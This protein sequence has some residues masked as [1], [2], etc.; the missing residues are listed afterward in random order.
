MQ[1]E[2]ENGDASIVTI[3][4]NNEDDVDSNWDDESDNDSA[5]M[6]EDNTDDLA[7]VYDCSN[8]QEIS[9]EN[10]YTTSELIFVE[11]YDLVNDFTIPRKAYR[12]L[13]RLMNTVI[14]DKEKL[15]R[16]ETMMKRQASFEAHSYDVSVNG[17]KLYNLVDQETSCTYCNSHRFQVDNPVKSLAT[18]KIMSLG[19]IIS[20]LLAN[21]DTRA[22]L[23]YRHKYDNRENPE[24]NVIDDF[25]DGEKYKAFKNNN[26][27]QSKNDVAIA[28]VKDGFVTTK[29]GGRPL[30]MIHVFVLSYDPQK[31]YKGGIFNSAMHLT[32]KKKPALFPSYLSVILAEM[33]ALLE[34]ICHGG[35]F[36][37]S[38]AVYKFSNLGCQICYTHKVHPDNRSHGMYFPD[39]NAP[40]R[41]TQ[42][43][44]DAD[45]D[46]GFSGRSILT[47]LD[48]FAGPQSLVFDELH[49]LGRGVSSE[50]YQMLLAVSIAPSNTKLF[51]YISED[52]FE[53]EQYPF[54]IPR[55]RWI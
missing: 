43:Y 54:Y 15:E 49:T 23:R 25:F 21:P 13:L 29:R 42:D 22:E 36:E 28:L 35:V 9:S 55:Q 12:R 1:I 19:D 34:H 16:V 38:R 11:L 52:G 18:V 33:Y 48:V 2:A 17:C 4:P 3:A 50:L 46:L 10:T 40:L 6:V 7:C 30:T 26:N 37:F 8:L 27:F 32:W 45:P 41:T 51:Y 39:S 31:R 20:R 24:P 44:S 47:Q 14:R 5:R 53:V